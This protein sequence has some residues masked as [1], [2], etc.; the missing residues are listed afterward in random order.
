MK[1]EKKNGEEKKS[2]C[3]GC[4]LQDFYKSRRANLSIDP[5]LTNPL[6]SSTKLQI[7]AT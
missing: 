6:N 5:L 3:V 4:F 1:G 2:V 7:Q